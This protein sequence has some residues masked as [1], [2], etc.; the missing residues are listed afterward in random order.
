MH[1]IKAVV[2]DLGKVLVDFDYSIAARNIAARSKMGAREIMEY[3][4]L[5]PLLYR[6]ETGLMTTLQFYDQVRAV[7]GFNGT[8]EEFA[9]F[10]GDIFTPISPMVAL[11]AGLRE[12]GLPT[13]I[14]SNTNE[15]AVD[16]IR[17]NYPFFAHFDGYALSY[18]QKSMKPDV[19]IYEAV[20]RITGRRGGEILYVDDRPENIEV[21]VSRGWRTVLQE[22]PDNTVRAVKD[23]G[24]LPED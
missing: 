7:T 18:E 23:A 11:H 5:D 13:F 12:Q 24:L 6:Y 15:L 22:T 9:G 16:H 20:E 3:F 19:K 2:F 21:G 14:F 17:R 8:M 10:F 1:L 4:S